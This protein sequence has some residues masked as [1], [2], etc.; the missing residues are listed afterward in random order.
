LNFKLTKRKYF[1]EA[2][3]EGILKLSGSVT[4]IIILLIVVFLFS[5]GV[6]LFKKPAIE[7]GYELVVNSQ[8]PVSNLTSFEVK[9]IFDYEIEVWS[10][11]GINNAEDEILVFRLNDIESYVTS[12]EE[13][14]KQNIA[15]TLSRIIESNPGMIG[16]IPQ[17]YVNEDFEA[18]VL[19]LGEI[20]PAEFF[21]C[22]E[23][24][25]TA[26]PAPQYGILPIILGTL[27]VSL[28]AIL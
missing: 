13:L 22:K 28:G 15:R 24:Y 8:N 3:W 19:D 14:E 11:L 12:E 26:H 16:F 17:Q 21:A 5:Q 23:W 7:E 20:K 2:L 18:K 9:E 1:L 4:S 10:A 27:W 6:G 25:P